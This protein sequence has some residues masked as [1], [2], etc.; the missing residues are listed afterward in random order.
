L[1]AKENPRPKGLIS[2]GGKF[3]GE[4]PVETLMRKRR[5]GTLPPVAALQDHDPAMWPVHD[6]PS[7]T[8]REKC[9]GFT[10]AAVA[11]A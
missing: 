5:R 9:S 1:R 7:R 6:P 3:P 8:N 10:S 2:N 4:E 11:R